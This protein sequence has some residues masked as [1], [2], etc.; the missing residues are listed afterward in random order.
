MSFQI[1]QVMNKAKL[2][3]IE[4]IFYFSLDFELNHLYLR[5]L[6]DR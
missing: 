4:K 5:A 2:Q 6:L 3:Y 1:I